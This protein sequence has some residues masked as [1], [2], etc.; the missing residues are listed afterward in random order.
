M[1]DESPYTIEYRV[2]AATWLHESDGTVAD[3]RE[4]KSKLR[5]RFGI[6]PPDARVMKSWS[7][8]L[9]SSG[10]ILDKSRSGRPSASG[11]TVNQIR[12]CI[13]EN[14]KYST[15]GI[16]HET[17]V[18]KIVGASYTTEKFRVKAI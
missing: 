16:C 1:A 13:D 14:P 4:V 10:S 12:S 2:L 8:K 11:D 9:F 7:V 5:N 18:A 17:G 15:R 6:Q 3:V